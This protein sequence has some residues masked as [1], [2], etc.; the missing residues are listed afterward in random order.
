MKGVLRSP[1]PHVLGRLVV[2]HLL[3]ICSSLG[4]TKE[5]PLNALWSMESMRFLSPWDRRGFSLRNSRSKLLQ[6][7]ADFCGWWDGHVS[8]TNPTKPSFVAGTLSAGA[9]FVRE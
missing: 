7:L 2:L 1:S 5:K 8:L 9:E 6:S 4:L 3:I